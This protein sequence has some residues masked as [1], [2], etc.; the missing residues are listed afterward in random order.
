MD[1]TEDLFRR[2]LGRAAQLRRLPESTY[3]VQFHPRR[4]R[5]RA[6]PG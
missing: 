5:D 6:V 2:A 4:G 3:R 1:V